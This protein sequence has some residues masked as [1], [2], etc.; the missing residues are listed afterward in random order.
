M[1]K[2]SVYQTQTNKGRRC[3][4]RLP[5]SPYGTA[6]IFSFAQVSAVKSNHL[7]SASR[8]ASRC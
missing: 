3:N 1:R 4:I 8:S 5:I 6:A 2:E 7:G